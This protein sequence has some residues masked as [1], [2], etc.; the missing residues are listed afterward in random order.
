MV[1]LLHLAIVEAQVVESSLLDQLSLILHAW[2][3]RS[4]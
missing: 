4:I 3:G 2:I 1:W